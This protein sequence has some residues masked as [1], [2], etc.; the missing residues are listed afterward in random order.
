MALGA[1]ATIN[2]LSVV[3]VNNHKH[4][5]DEYRDDFDAKRDGRQD[6]YSYLALGRARIQHS[7]HR[8]VFHIL[9]LSPP[10]TA[11]EMRSGAMGKQPEPSLPYSGGGRGCGGMMAKLNMFNYILFIVITISPAY[12]T[13]C[14]DTS[15]IAPAV[16]LRIIARHETVVSGHEIRESCFAIVISCPEINI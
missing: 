1:F 6:E 2:I 16:L 4:A 15:A 5:R 13:P 14:A 9:M 11:P 3:I 8:I 10:E 7:A 12:A